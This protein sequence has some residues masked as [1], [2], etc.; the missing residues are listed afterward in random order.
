MANSQRIITGRD[1]LRELDLPAYV[2][3]D[4]I[5][6][7][8]KYFEE[9]ME[10]FT[11]FYKEIS[12]G[13]VT[14]GKQGFAIRFLFARCINDLVSGHHLVSHGYIIQ[15]Y[16]VTRGILESLDKI[17]LFSNKKSYAE[18]WMDKP[19]E[20]R[21]KLTPGKVRKLLGKDSYDRIYGHFCE[22]GSHPTFISSRTMSYKA[23]RK[24][25][26]SSIVVRIGPTDLV[27]PIL[28]SLGFCYLLMVTLSLSLTEH[29]GKDKKQNM[30]FLLE[31]LNY[32]D[33][34]INECAQPAFK[35]YGD[36]LEGGFESIIEELNILKNQFGK[37]G[38]VIGS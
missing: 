13:R 38:I 33:K 10:R 24:D 37:L 28:F 34:F 36:K 14:T 9:S 6:C 22:M 17:E 7:S 20:A 29:L 3:V 2:D 4:F 11:E 32:F 16:S 15:F 21:T 27:H 30:T 5:V 35:K 31:E 26:T 25:G 1:L 19:N 23:V 18:L 12:S 8:N